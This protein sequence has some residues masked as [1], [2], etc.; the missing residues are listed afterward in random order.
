MTNA[1]VCPACGELIDG[2]AVPRH[3]RDVRYPSGVVFRV[4]FVHPACA[5]EPDTPRAA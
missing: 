1:Q 5:D 2:R 3:V 4:E